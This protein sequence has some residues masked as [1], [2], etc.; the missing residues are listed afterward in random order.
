MLIQL[1]VIQA[2][3]FIVIILVLKKLLYSETAKEADRLR[4]L[5]DEFAHKEKELQVKIDVA[6]KDAVEKIARAEQDAQKYIETKGKE[7]DE[8]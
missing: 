5:K 4:L 7:A 1:I 2:V 3:T 6:K 8:L